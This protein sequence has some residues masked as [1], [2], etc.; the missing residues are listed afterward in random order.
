MV[1]FSAIGRRVAEQLVHS[2]E[3]ILII[4]RDPS[5]AEI[6]STLGYLVVEGDAG[7]DGGV[8]ERAAIERARVLTITIG[9]A[10]RRLT[11]TLLARTLN[12]RLR[13]VVLA[14][15]DPRREVLE[16]AGATAVIIVDDLVARALIDH[17]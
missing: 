14:A 5:T 7:V 12:P 9:N 10:D 13:I 15:D 6:A 3:H 1:G 8:L 11:I 17:M 16:R 4:E 2:G